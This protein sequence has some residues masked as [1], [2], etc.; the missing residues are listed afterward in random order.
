MVAIFG[1][2]GMFLA[3]YTS[4][5]QNNAML[6]L[7][8][9]FN[10]TTGQKEWVTSSTLLFAAPTS[11]F[12][13]T[14]STAFGRR[15]VL[16]LSAG[17]N[18][19]GGLGCAGAPTYGVLIIARSILGIAI[20]LASTTSPMYTG[21]TSPPVHRG[22]VVGLAEFNVVGG[23]FVACMICALTMRFSD[24]GLWRTPMG[25]SVIFALLQLF[26]QLLLPESPRWLVQQGRDAEAEQVLLQINSDPKEVPVQLQ[27]I[28]E[29]VAEES[30][31]SSCSTALMRLYGV[32]RLRRAAFV[33]IMLMTAQQLSGINALMAYSGI[34]FDDLFPREAAMWVASL[35]VLVQLGGVASCFTLIDMVGRRVLLI[36]SMTL[37]V[38]TLLFLSLAFSLEPSPSTDTFLL[39]TMALFLIAYGF[40]LGTIPWI[41]IAEIY[42]IDVRAVAVGQCIVM[43]WLSNFVVAAVF[44][45]LCDWVGKNGTFA[46][47]AGLSA[48]CVLGFVRYVPETRGMSLEK[49]IYLFDDPYPQATCWPARIKDTA[50][51]KGEKS[52]LLATKPV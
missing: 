41:I 39:T 2:M 26:G 33:G 35:A 6:P 11:L 14:L 25:I 46:V 28:R 15:P 21:E 47:F 40:G 45:D 24:S 36:T 51:R 29:A 17:L 3:G 19:L 32:T 10:L 22:R 12:S 23:Q 27:D 50:E 5:V 16:V 1:N 30:Q 7:A 8:E 34:L 49:T 44:L 52:K 48:L 4:A 43:T 38:I 9:D 20:G 37:I 31:A 42:P 18:V 13:S